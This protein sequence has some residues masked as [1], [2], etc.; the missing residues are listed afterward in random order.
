MLRSCIPTFWQARRSLPS[1]NQTFPAY[2]LTHHTSRVFRLP[3]PHPCRK[4]PARQILQRRVTLIFPAVS[5][6]KLLRTDLP[7]APVF[8]PYFCGSSHLMHDTVSDHFPSPHNVCISDWYSPVRGRSCNLS[9]TVIPSLFPGIL[10]DNPPQDRDCKS[11]GHSSS[12]LRNCRS[13]LRLPDRWS[14]KITF[15][16]PALHTVPLTSGT[17]PPVWMVFWYIHKTPVFPARL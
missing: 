9:H 4:R 16:S 14:G 12:P 3:S 1:K 5:S 10:R 8:F 17:E 11:S 2:R 6:L 13:Q 15:L 7:R